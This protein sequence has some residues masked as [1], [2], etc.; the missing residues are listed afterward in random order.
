M[1]LEGVTTPDRLYE[2]YLQPLGQCLYFRD[3][4]HEPDRQ[5]LVEDELVDWVMAK[6]NGLV[7]RVGQDR[8]RAE[9]TMPHS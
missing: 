1:A 8:A 7:S 6:N 3:F 9:A 5:R 2:D 4:A